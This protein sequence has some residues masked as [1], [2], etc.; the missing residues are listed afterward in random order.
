M[1]R[2][3][4][5]K[6]IQMVDLK[7][8]YLKIQ[9][10]VDAAM[11]EVVSN[12]SFINGPAVSQFTSNLA[13][14]LGVKHLI[15]CANGTDGLQVALM[16]LGLKAGDEILCP[17]FTFVATAEVA[18]V[19]GLQTVLVDV[20]PDTFMIDLQSAEKAIT[21][22]TK[23][24]VPVHL[25]GQCAPMEQVLAFAKKYKL[26]VIEDTAQAIGATYTFSDGSVAKA[27][28]MGDIGTTSFFPSKNLGCFGDGGALF[29]NDDELAKKCKSIVNHGMDERYYYDCIGIN[30]R[31]DAIQAAVLDVKLKYL[32]SYNAA[33]L[34]AANKYDQAFTTCKLL[35]IPKRAANSNHVFH[36]YTLK[37]DDGVDREAL[38]KYMSDKGIPVKVYYPKAL[39]SFAPYRLDRYKEED[40]SVTN[41]LCNRVIS[42]PMHTE[43]DEVTIDYICSSLLSFLNAVD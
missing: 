18:E 30:S 32:D 15:P 41:D 26:R 29:T 7:G 3:Y 34:A 14:Y 36:Q 40:F 27:G 16:A 22:K 43:L 5:M 8:Q 19:L 11:G 12:C 20:D 2:K 39:H 28:T 23:A 13:S 38:L 25:F 31:L 24:I 6:N 35:Q 1:P 9:E 10:E 37:L 4:S 17:D 42:L 21:Q 33:R